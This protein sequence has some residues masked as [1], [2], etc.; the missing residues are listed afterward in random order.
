[1]ATTRVILTPESAHFPATGNAALSLSAYQNRPMLAFDAGATEEEAWWTFIAPQG[2]SGA[3]SAVISYYMASATS[4]TCAWNVYVEA[5][6]ASEDLDSNN[7]PYWASTNDSSADTVP[8]TA[9]YIQQTTVTLT[10]ADSIAAG[11]YARLRL[12]R[13][14]S[15]D[16]AT[17]DACVIAVEIREA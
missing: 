3:L 6:T 12:V 4:G 16:S 2:L 15:V 8:G 9:G 14:T 10:N 1:M 5:P 17:G 13:D 11:N 7:T